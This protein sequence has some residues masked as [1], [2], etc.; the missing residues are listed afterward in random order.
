MDQNNAP[1]KPEHLTPLP[2]KSFKVAPGDVVGGLIYI[3]DKP[4]GIEEGMIGISIANPSYQNFIKEQLASLEAGSNTNHA[5][6]R[7]YDQIRNLEDYQKLT[8]EEDKINFLIRHKEHVKHR[9]PV[10]LSDLNKTFFKFGKL[11]EVKTFRAYYENVG[12]G[13]LLFSAYKDKIAVDD[14]KH[15]AAQINQFIN[16]EKNDPD[17]KKPQDQDVYMV[18]QDGELVYGRT[19]PGIRRILKTE[20]GQKFQILANPFV[21]GATGGMSLLAFAGATYGWR[22]ALLSRG[23]I[24]TVNSDAIVE[25]IATKIANI[26]G[27]ESQDIEKING[28]YG[29]GGPPKIGTIVTWSAGCK[30]GTGRLAGG[31][32]NKTNV[33]V[34]CDENNN[35]IRVD[36]NNKMVRAIPDPTNKGKL[37]YVREGKRVPQSVY[38]KAMSV[39]EHRVSGLGESLASFICMG[40]RDGIGEVGQNKVFKKIDPPKGKHTLQFFGIDFGKAYEKANPIVDPKVGNL[41]DDFSFKNPSNRKERF[42]NA[43]VLYDNPLREKMKGIYLMAA[44]R[45][46]LSDEQKKMIVA[47]YRVSG[48]V[49]FADK[50]AGYPKSLEVKYKDQLTSNRTWLENGDLFLIKKEEN[51]YRMMAKKEGLPDAEKKHYLAYADRLGD[52]YK[53]AKETD[54]KVLNIFSKRLALTPSQIDVIDNLEKLTAKKVHI[55]SPD[56]KVILNHIRVESKHRTPWQLEPSADG[57]TFVLTCDSRNSDIL[58]KLKTM[59][60]IAG[61]IT[62]QNTKTNNNQVTI[63]LDKEQFE[64]IATVLKE[65]NVAKARKLTQFRTDKVKDAFDNELNGKKSEIIPPQEKVKAKSE[66]KV[67]QH[68]KVTIDV[69]LPQPKKGFW[70]AYKA[71][72]IDHKAAKQVKEEKL[73]HQKSKVTRNRRNS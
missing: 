56:G 72:N 42:L 1:S 39:S 62:I 58:S 45:N 40:D 61:E 44:L 70:A 59:P 13:G 10:T 21:V 12:M 24:S 2:I 25:T 51:E 35:H 60:E 50:L 36:K 22:A 34:C 38:D 71:A 53:T 68:K 57:N 31:E 6:K 54:D 73:D 27:F 43:S 47:E 37:V 18:K 30:D 4:V 67:A 28:D 46:K 26:R 33:M 5:L 69:P 55:L 15:F 19:G 8:T 48:D 3:M 32:K 7:K 49:E 9:Y 14:T 41:Q 11:H 64:K 23:T 16:A 29:K 65:E 52:I 20:I 63:T 66:V 17:K